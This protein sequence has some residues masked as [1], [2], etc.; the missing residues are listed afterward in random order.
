[1]N[2]ILKITTLSITISFAIFCIILYL[3]YKDLINIELLENKGI[4]NIFATLSFLIG[5]LMI[6][7]SVYLV[8]FK[9]KYAYKTFPIYGLSMIAESIELLIGGTD[10]AWFSTLSSILLIVAILIDYKYKTGLYHIFFGRKI[11][12]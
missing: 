8:K 5:L 9:N 12:E 3:L 10:G 2:K 1:M 11:K 7:G 6:F 4:D